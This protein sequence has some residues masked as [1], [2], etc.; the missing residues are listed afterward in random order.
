MTEAAIEWQRR[1]AMRVGRT[2][3]DVLRHRAADT[4]DDLAYTFLVDGEREERRVSYAELERQARRI[5]VA[6]AASGGDRSPVLVVFDPGLELIAALFGC[7]L[8][9]TI[10]VPTYPPDPRDLASG[11]ARIRRIVADAG[12]TVV[13]TTGTVRD[14]VHRAAG[15]DALDLAW[16][17]VDDLP[18]APDVSWQPPTVAPEQV[19]FLQYT[20]GSTGD[21]RGVMVT[22][23]NIVA[24]AERA[25]AMLAIDTQSVVVSWL[26]AYHDMGLIGTVLI[27]MY[28]GC[29]AVQMSPLAFLERPGRWLQAISRY[30]GT[31]S[32]APNFAYD[33]VLRK[34]TPAERADLDLRTWRGALNGAEPVR[35]DTC[36]AFIA[37]F[38]PCGLRREFFVPCYGLAEATLMVAAGPMRRGPVV[39][40]VDGRALEGDRVAVSRPTSGVARTLVASGTVVAGIEVVIVDPR[41]RAARAEN[42]VGEIWVAGDIVAA[43]YWGRPEETSATFGAQLADGRGPYLRTGDLG[44]LRDGLL[45]VTGRR[46]DVIVIRGRNLYPQDLEHAAVSAHPALRS[47]GGAAFAVDNGRSE[48]LVLVHE[49]A[50]DDP[51][52]L[53]AA[54]EAI[55]ETITRVFLVQVHAVALLAPRTLPKTSSGKVRR[56]ACRAMFEA[57]KLAV[58]YRWPAHTPDG[59]RLGGDAAAIEAWLIRTIAEVRNVPRT[60]IDRDA[61]LVA[62]GIDSAEAAHVA[63]ELELRLGRRVPLRLVM[64]Q[65]TIGALASA[66]SEVSA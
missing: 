29:R 56:R 53:R 20:S 30:G 21:P 47:G 34:T 3:G 40:V 11:E 62:L 8:A 26:P 42:E 64:E 39:M 31:V 43:G 35:A 7:F 58:R 57:G 55:R 33:L 10:A 41:A 54:V 12:A 51:E 24:H 46:K 17:C 6:L 60:E 14:R 37:A 52:T 5:A 36:E 13:L 23:A 50:A 22:H 48:Q 44:F 49:V 38:A 28:V 1:F 65:P 19:A 18:V 9:G 61:A 15:I 16:L 4:P 66:L 45:F 25:A 27:P 59:E 2:L 32:P 63:A